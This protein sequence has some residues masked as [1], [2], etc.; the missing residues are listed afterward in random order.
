MRSAP[1]YGDTY[2]KDQR[3]LQANELKLSFY[4][5]MSALTMA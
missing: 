4:Y 2:A 1:D 5:F 3:L